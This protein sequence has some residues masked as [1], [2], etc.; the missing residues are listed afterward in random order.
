[1][2]LLDLVLVLTAI[3]AAV[4]GYRLGFLV[5]VVSW[6]GLVA[7]VVLAAALLPSVLRRWLWWARAWA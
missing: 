6:L 4:G 5:R 7:G 3:S 1:M 2:N